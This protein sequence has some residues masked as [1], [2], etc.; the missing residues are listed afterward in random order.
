MK[1]LLL[2]FPLILSAQD[3]TRT[4]TQRPQFRRDTVRVVP[5]FDRFIQPN[6][7]LPFVVVKIKGKDAL[8]LLDTGSSSSLIDISQL[9][10]YGLNSM[11][12][13]NALFSGIGGSTQMSDVTNINSIQIGTK[14][15]AANFLA[16]DLRDVRALIFNGVNVNITGILGSDFFEYHKVMIDYNR[17]T[18]LFADN[19]TMPFRRPTQR[20]ANTTRR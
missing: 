18:L 6:N 1:Y 10:N 12:I 14:E 11:F 8:M 5:I 13:S 2:L 7:N 17:N 15:Y 3:T 16:A 20:S 19:M 4:R 9:K